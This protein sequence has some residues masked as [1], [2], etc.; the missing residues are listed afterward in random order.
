MWDEYYRNTDGLLKMLQLW[1]HLLFLDDNRLTKHIFEWEYGNYFGNGNSWNIQIKQI[2]QLVDIKEDD[3]N[4]LIKVNLKYFSI[5]LHGVM[6]REWQR[7]ILVKPKLRTY[8][9][10]NNSFKEEEYLSKLCRGMHVH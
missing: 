7:V 2:F 9:T 3:F 10:F 4:N 5:L 8:I 6:E 1:N